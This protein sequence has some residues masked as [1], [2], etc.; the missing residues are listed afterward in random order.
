MGLFLCLNVDFDI[1]TKILLQFNISIKI[2]LLVVLHVV[3]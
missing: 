3:L 2:L 1:V